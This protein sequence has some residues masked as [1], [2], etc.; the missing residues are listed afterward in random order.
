METKAAVV[1]LNWNGIQFLKKFLPAVVESSSGIA[2]VIVADNASTDESRPWTREK[3][4]GVEWIQL[5]NNYGFA[6]GYNRAL[7]KINAEIFI[8]LNSDVEVN[9]NWIQPLL[10]CLGSEPDIA[11]CQPKILSFDKR[12][13]FEYAGA[14]GGFIDFL[15][16]P[17]CRGRIFHNH[18]LDMGQYDDTTE[19]FW[20]TGACLAVKAK[21]FHEAGGFDEDFFAH[22]EEIDLCWRMKNSGHRIFYCGD[23]T[24]HHV[25]G[26]TLQKINPQKTFLNFRNSLFCLVKNGRGWKV[27]FLVLY[28]LFLDGIASLKFIAE[29]NFMHFLA[30]FRSHLS[31]YFH[32]IPM[33]RKRRKLAKSRNRI[34]EFPMYRKSI[35][36]EFYLRGLR[37]FSALDK[38]RF[39]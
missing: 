33:I 5:D 30:V 23:S 12:N 13:E 17:F 22:M 20:A 18:E 35:V 32:L 1:I 28:R 24:V 26:A 3:F 25:G 8:L 34:S 9:G 6:G 11:A 10:N 37:T 16:Y 27:P 14:A 19:I 36:F 38:S 2:R 4:P 7:Q 29:G 39:R 15:G 31:F 21:A